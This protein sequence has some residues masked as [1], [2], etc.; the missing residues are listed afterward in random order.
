MAY[1]EGR[2]GGGGKAEGEERREKKEGREATIGTEGE[3]AGSV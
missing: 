2:P 1:V 3:G